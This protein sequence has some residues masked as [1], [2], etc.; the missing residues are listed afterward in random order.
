[1]LT[2]IKEQIE[3]LPAKFRPIKFDINDT[4]AIQTIMFGEL[5]YQDRC[6]VI[7][8]EFGCC[9]GFTIYL[10]QRASEYY[11]EQH[12]EDCE[13]SQTYNCSKYYVRKGTTHEIK[14]ETGIKYLQRWLDIATKGSFITLGEQEFQV[15][16][17]GDK[18]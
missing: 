3:N 1:M 11:L 12:K 14:L 15:L 5:K 7:P 2:K 9:E 16:V 6:N 17:Y 13:E 10:Y 8:I 4:K 18:N